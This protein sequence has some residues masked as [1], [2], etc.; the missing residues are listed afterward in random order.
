MQYEVG[1]HYAKENSFPLDVKKGTWKP[2]RIFSLTQTFK[3]NFDKEVR[4]K[5]LDYMLNTPLF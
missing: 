4:L 3:L 1:K 2:L 5:F